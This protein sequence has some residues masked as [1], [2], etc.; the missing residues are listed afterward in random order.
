MKKA[1][2]KMIYFKNFKDARA[3]QEK[4]GGALRFDQNRKMYYVSRM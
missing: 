3:H 2:Y 4:H 1:S